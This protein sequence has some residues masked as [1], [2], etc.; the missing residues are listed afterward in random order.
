M[1][2]DGDDV[3]IIVI[4]VECVCVDGVCG[5]RFV[6]DVVGVARRFVRVVGRRREGVRARVVEC[7]VVIVGDEYGLGREIDDVIFK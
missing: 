1:N 4:V 7:G 2:D 6:G 5:V 3:I